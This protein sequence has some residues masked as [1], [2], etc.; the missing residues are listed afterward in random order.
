[1]H[2]ASKDHNFVHTYPNQVKKY[3]RKTRKNKFIKK[4]FFMHTIIFKYAKSFPK[5][6]VSQLNLKGTLLNATALS[7]VSGSSNSTMLS[8][9]RNAKVEK[10]Y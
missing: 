5:L 6:M 4:V 10:F 9:A 2:A 7:L 8:W 1:M 3:T